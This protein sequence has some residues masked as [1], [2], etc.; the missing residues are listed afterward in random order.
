MNVYCFPRKRFWVVCFLRKLFMPQQRNMYCFLRKLLVMSVSWGNMYCFLRK[1]FGDVCFLRKLFI[2]NSGMCVVS[3]GNFLV[4][5]V[6]WG[7][8]F[9]MSVS[10]GNYSWITVEYVLGVIFKSVNA[11]G[12]SF[13]FNLYILSRVHISLKQSSGTHTYSK[14]SVCPNFYP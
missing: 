11:V 7:N 3:W 8:F 10:S 13:L 5:F 6:S 14:I 12:N 4:M 1:H 2:D 9:R